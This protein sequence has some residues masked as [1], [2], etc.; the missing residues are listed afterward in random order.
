MRKYRIHDSFRPS[1]SVD[2]VQMRSVQTAMIL[3]RFLAARQSTAEKVVEKSTQDK[4]NIT[5]HLAYDNETNLLCEDI[6]VESRPS[7]C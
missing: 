1:Q 2:L 5:S 3:E 6:V 7:L 4:I